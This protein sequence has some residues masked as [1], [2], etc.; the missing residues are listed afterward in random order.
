MPFRSRSPLAS[1]LVCVILSVVAGC[2]RKTSSSAGA[3]P[4]QEAARPTA[5]APRAIER[6]D[7]P[8]VAVGPKGAVVHVRWNA[9]PGTA[10]NEEAPFRVRWNVSEGLAEAPP[11]MKATGHNVK[12]GF[13]V[14]VKPLPSAPRATLDGDLELVVCDAVA[15]STCLP[16]RREMHLDF[17]VTANGLEQTTLD[18]RLPD[19]RLD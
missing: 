12:D 14:N 1:L 8:E 16:V 17:V 3:Q 6:V 2:N 15:H 19:A 7:A 18:V 4:D 9:P 10:L 11:E 5:K 13:D